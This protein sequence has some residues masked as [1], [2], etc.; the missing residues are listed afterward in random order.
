MQ[1][2]LP[3]IYCYINEYNLTELLKLGNN[4]NLIYLNYD[5]KNNVSTVLKLRDFCRKTKRKLF[6][7]NDIKLALNLKLN[8]IYIPSYN[9]NKLLLSNK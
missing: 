4:I 2:F 5:E 1:N 9:K 3:R 8:G 7:S 6:I